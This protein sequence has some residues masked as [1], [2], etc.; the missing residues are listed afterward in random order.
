M[1]KLKTRTTLVQN[2]VKSPQKLNTK[3]NNIAL[4]IVRRR[5]NYDID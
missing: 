4:G 3:T 1:K 5:N 2:V